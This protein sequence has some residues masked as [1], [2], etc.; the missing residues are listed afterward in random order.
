MD[1]SHL[2]AKPKLPIKVSLP[3]GK[4]VE[5]VAWKTTP[6]EIAQGIR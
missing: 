2:I 4:E 5:G 1:Q 3:D 6:Y